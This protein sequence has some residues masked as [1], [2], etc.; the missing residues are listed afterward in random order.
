M[1]FYDATL[2]RGTS[3]R[4]PFQSGWGT[5]FYVFDGS[6]EAEGQVF[7]EAESG[8]V[9]SAAGVEMIRAVDTA[10]VVAF[11]INPAAPVRRTG[12]VGDGET[13]R[14]FAQ[15]VSSAR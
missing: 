3:I 15:R 7:E 14:A 2:D 6:V 11:V 1:H 9:S 12:S 4:L 13:V 10:L 5:Y 8:L